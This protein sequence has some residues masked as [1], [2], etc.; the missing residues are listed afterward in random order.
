VKAPL[1]AECFANF[2]CKLIDTSQIRKYSLFVFQVVK[3][4]AAT[5]PRTPKMLHYTGD[6]VFI[7]SGPTVNLKKNFRPDRL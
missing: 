5:S 7:T 2:E 3:A 4:H 6:G 1:I